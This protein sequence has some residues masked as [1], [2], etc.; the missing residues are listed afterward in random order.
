MH[1]TCHVTQEMPE[2]QQVFRSGLVGKNE[3]EAL[4]AANEQLNQEFTIVNEYAEELEKGFSK[5]IWPLARSLFEHEKKRRAEQAAK[6][7]AIREQ[8]QKEIAEKKRQ[9]KKR[10]QG[11]LAAF[12]LLDK[13][14]N[15]S[16]DKNEF[17][18]FLNC[19]CNIGR[20]FEADDGLELTAAEFVELCEELMHE[21]KPRPHLTPGDVLVT[22]FRREEVV[23][24]TLPKDHD[25]KRRRIEYT[26][27]G[28]QRNLLLPANSKPG[29]V[30]EASFM[31]YKVH[32]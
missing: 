13:D 27:D 9:K 29:E 26:I 18:S 23:K 11:I 7:K 16:L 15:G 31:G 21:M 25:P 17:L 12:I 4:R 22:P 14:N 28:V 2:M 30:V 3:F 1:G 19:T 24:I 32:P 20:V 10:R 8:K 6:K 5:Q